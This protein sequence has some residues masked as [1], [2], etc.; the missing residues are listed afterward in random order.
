MPI[1]DNLIFKASGLTLNSSTNHVSASVTNL[2]TNRAEAIDISTVS[3]GLLVVH[4]GNAPTGTT[5]TLA[6]FFEVADEFGNWVQTSSATSIGGALLTS[7]GYTYGQI[8][9]GYTLGNQGRIRWELTGTTPSFTGVGF[10]VYG[11]A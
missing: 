10:S 1:R 8:S 7:S 11:R 4:V 5:P 3:N 2:V 6:V 9:T